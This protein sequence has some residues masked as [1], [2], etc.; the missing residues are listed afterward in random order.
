MTSVKG[1][2]K[3][4]HGD[5]EIEDIARSGRSSK[6]SNPEM[7]LLIRSV[8]RRIAFKR[9]TQILK[10]TR[11]REGVVIIDEQLGKLKLSAKWVSKCSNANQEE[12]RMEISKFIVQT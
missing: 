11:E 9:F 1:C 6:I 5:S 2:D 10:I 4:K 8:D 3:F 7:I 12:Y